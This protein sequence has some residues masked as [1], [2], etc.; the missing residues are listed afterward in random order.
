MDLPV[1]GLGEQVRRVAVTVLRE[2]ALHAPPE[3]RAGLLQLALVLA[4][5]PTFHVLDY[6]VAGAV[7]VHP[8]IGC[9]LWLSDCDVTKA[10]EQGF[11]RQ[12]ATEGR[13][14]LDLGEDGLLRVGE[15]LLG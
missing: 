12:P 3:V 2:E 15:E 6:T 9:G 4:E 7:V 11:D 1:T 10:I 5:R 13:F 8:L 14:R